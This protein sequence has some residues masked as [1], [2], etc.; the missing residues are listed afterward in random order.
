MRIV[1]LA[2]GATLALTSGIASAESRRAGTP[3]VLAPT[4]AVGHSAAIS[5]SRS[6]NGFS[7][8]PVFPG[9]GISGVQG[10]PY[11]AVATTEN[12]TTFLDGNRFVQTQTAR[13]FRDSQGRTRME[14]SFSPGAMRAGQRTPSTELPVHAFVTIVDPLRAEQYMLQ[15]HDRKVDV[16][17]TFMTGELVRPPLDAPPPAIQLSLPGMGFGFGSLPDSSN[18]VSLGEKVIE[19]VR[20]VG[21]RLD[22]T[23]AAG[24]VGNEKPITIT[25]EQ[26]FSPELGV[27]VMSTQRSSIGNE[28]TYQLRQIARDEPAAELFAVPADYTRREIAP[29]QL[30][31]FTKP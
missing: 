25:S 31:S 5:A 22:H 12:V 11:S 17:P 13:H 15:P 4:Q 8:A 14:Q 21:H 3:D 16:L 10:A 26:W 30:R 28:S 23:V 1:K 20:V 9:A 18:L 7:V 19:G 2:L 27:V 29:M 24:E 6:A